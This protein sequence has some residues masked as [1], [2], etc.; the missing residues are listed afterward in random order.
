MLQ[1]K[2]AEIFSSEILTIKI[3][4]VTEKVI[5]R[6]QILKNTSSAMVCNTANKYL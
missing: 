5:Y 3:L 1:E 6:K 4:N 2:T